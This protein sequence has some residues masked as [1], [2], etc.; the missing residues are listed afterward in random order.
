MASFLITEINQCILRIA[1]SFENC[2]SDYASV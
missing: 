1:V 2:V